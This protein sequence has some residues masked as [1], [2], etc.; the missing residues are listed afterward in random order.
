MFNILIVNSIFLLVFAFVLLLPFHL[1]DVNSRYYR[2]FLKFI[3]DLLKTRYYACMLLF[4]VTGIIVGNTARVVSESIVFG[5][6]CIIIFI[7]IIFPFFFWLPFVIRN[8]FPDKYKGIWKKIGDW[9]EGPRYLF[10]R[11]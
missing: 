10:K 1:K 4:V 8:L 9:L 6:L 5:L 2:G 11:E 7:I 3:P